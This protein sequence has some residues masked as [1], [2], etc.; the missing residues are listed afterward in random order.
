MRLACLGECMIELSD[1]DAADGRP[2][3]GFAGDTLNTAIYLSRSVSSD[4]V[5]VDYVTALGTDQLSDRM[6]AFIAGQGVGTGHI[7]RREDR[8]PGLYAIELDAHGERSFRY[9]RSEAAAR[10]LFDAGGLAAGDLEHFD[11]LYLSGISLAILSP[12]ARQLL[13]RAAATLKAAGKWVVFDSNY[14]PRLWESVE[15]ARETMKAMWHVTSL[16]L[17]SFDDE[18]A[19]WGGG[20]MDEV[21]TR[22]SGWGVPEIACKNG[23]SGPTLWRGS[24]LD[25]QDYPSA[26]SVVDTTSAGDA[27]NGGYL[28]ARLGGAAPEEAAM[29]GHRLAGAVIGH[30]GAIIPLAAMPAPFGSA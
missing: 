17:P 4:A 15:V 18:Q 19:L 3:L 14:R 26:A 13:I 6:V 20:T 23:A 25:A 27:F 12:P 29:A 9:W 11:G 30:R 10:S 22:L 2:A 1:L 28:G 21:V 24:V 7:I 16:G 8:L 5:S